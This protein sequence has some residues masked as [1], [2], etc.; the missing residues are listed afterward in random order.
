[1]RLSHL[2]LAAALVFAAFEVNASVVRDDLPRDLISSC[3]VELR[4]LARDGDSD[5][6]RFDLN[7]HCPELAKRI[8]L[9]AALAAMGPVE[10]DAAS[11]EGLRDLQSFAAGFHRQPS[12]PENFSPDFVGLDG[13]LVDVLI[14]ESM[15]DDLW[16]GFLR[17]LEQFARDGESAELK[18]FLNW[19]EELDPPPWLADVILKGSVVLILLLALMVIGNELRLAGVMQRIRRP[20]ML[21]EP[22]G[23]EETAPKPVAKSLDALA[24][25]PP[26]QLAAAILEIVTGTLAER[27]WVSAS[28]SLTNG[29]LVRQINQRQTGLSAAFTSLVNGTE[30]VIY[31]DRLPDDAS[32]QRLLATARKLIARARGASTVA[33]G[34][35][36]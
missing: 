29:E 9:S 2:A 3:L 20:R 8:G 36:G 32:R 5:S 34:G 22:A 11:I 15:D 26:R 33:S 27:G 24:H 19:L 13:L 4:A 35:S 25:L 30:K 18:R 23:T 12:P 31:G 14:E 17:W 10:V 16:Q 1:M 6:H 28:S 7:E 21:H